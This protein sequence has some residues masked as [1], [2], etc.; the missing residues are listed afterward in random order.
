MSTQPS[1]TIPEQSHQIRS[2]SG[3]LTAALSIARA[4]PHL[5]ATT[6]EATSREVTVHLHGVDAD[7]FPRWIEELEL[8]VSEE[9]PFYH[10][11]K[12][13]RCVTASGAFAEVQVNVKAYVAAAEAVAA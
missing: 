13:R 4:F 7:A 12:P 11:G 9:Q 6:V 3:P 5:P 10:S 1:P 8:T 2:A